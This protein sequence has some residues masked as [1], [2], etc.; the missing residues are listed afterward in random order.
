LLW[1]LLFLAIS[2]PGIWW[3]EKPAAAEK[4]TAPLLVTCALT[5]FVFW[6]GSTFGRG[7]LVLQG[8]G[9][10]VAIPLLRTRAFYRRWLGVVVAVAITAAA[11][12][13]NVAASLPYWRAYYRL[14]EDTPFVSMEDRVALPGPSLRP[15][16]LSTA[17]AADLA[18]L[19]IAVRVTAREYGYRNGQLQEVHEQ[20]LRTFVNSPGF[21]IGRKLRPDAA[22]LTRGDRQ[23]IRLPQ[24]VPRAY[25]AESSGAIEPKDAGAL[26]DGP[27]AL[28]NDAYI[29]F[30]YPAGS[31]YVKDRRHVAGFLPHGFSKVPEPKEHWVV[32]NIDLVSLL[33]HPQPLAYVSAD[34]PRMDELREAPTREL[35][36]FEAAALGRLLGGETLT[37]GE[38]G[39]HLRMLGSIRAVEQCVKCHGGE[40]GDLLGAFS[41]TLRKDPGAGRK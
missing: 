34:L 14:H 16:S 41:Y 32:E 6:F 30:A 37:V 21:G 22:R 11:Y 17:A 27:Q 38:A 31:G 9:L 13:L 19:D 5:P 25:P 24:P 12:A 7:V 8:L 4:W 39:D 18:K 2:F 29:D 28:H 1:P 35:D 40:R 26:W 36:A 20:T 15:A 33:L 10:T 23:D 3:S